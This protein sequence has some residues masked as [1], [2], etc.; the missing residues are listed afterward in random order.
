MVY[1]K[2]F[3]KIINIYTHICVQL[4]KYYGSALAIKQPRRVRQLSDIDIKSSI[5]VFG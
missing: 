3:L 1:L 5:I 2:S 4:F